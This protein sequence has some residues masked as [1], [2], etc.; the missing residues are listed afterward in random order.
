[1][2]S[3][4][5]LCIQLC[6]KRGIIPPSEILEAMKISS[7][8]GE[9]CLSSLSIVVPICEIISRILTSSTTIKCVDLSD[10]MLI[11]TGMSKILEALNNGSNITSLNLKGNN[12]SG[13]IASQLGDIFHH[14]NTLKHLYIKWNALGTDKA[15]FDK[16]CEGLC[17]NH[18]IEEIDLRY[19]QIT[20]Y[21]AE[22]LSNVLRKNRSLKIMNLA[23]NT[24]GLQGGQLILNGM[25]E[26][27]RIIQLNLRGNCIPT[28]II[29]A[30]DN[31]IHD[32][33]NKRIISQANITKT[34]GA[35]KITVLHDNSHEMC[36]TNSDGA[37][38]EEYRVI[39]RRMRRKLRSDRR[40]KDLF[41]VRERYDECKK[42][43]DDNSSSMSVEI[44]K[45][46]LNENDLCTNNEAVSSTNGPV[47]KNNSKETELIRKISEVN[48]I[49]QDRT[50]AI[51]ALT[52]EISMKDSEIEAAKMLSDQLRIKISQLEDENEKRVTEH[53]KEINDLKL[54][55]KSSEENW[56]K[57]YKELEEVNKTVVEK[58]KEWETKARYYEREIHKSSLEIISLRDKW[59]NKSQSYDNLI[60][61]SKTEI[62]RGKKELQE[63]ESRHK[64]ELNVLKNTLKET[65][66]ALEE[67]QI[68]LQKSRIELRDTLV[69]LSNVKSKL[70]Q[71][72]HTNAKYIRIDECLQK[73]K[74]EKLIIEEKFVDSQRT[75]ASL[76]RQITALENELI[77]PQRRYNLLK[78]DLDNEKE[79]ST[80]L[81]RELTE[82]RAHIKEQDIQMQM[83]NS[84]I[85]KLNTQINDIQRTYADDIR[86]R[87]REKKQLK[88][89]IVNKERDLNDLKAE[90]AQRASQLY[91][92]FGKYISSIRP[93]T[94]S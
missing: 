8:L 64:I 70:T 35:G 44:M 30:I 37:V 32:N 41:I 80:R 55:Q 84:Q 65:T 62:H 85:T 53:M 51:N 61:K 5:E 56:I 71:M 21:S 31:C 15:S 23:W 17:V 77:E 20:S 9:L 67:C 87:D 50:V 90:E 1:M 34:V 7:S 47:D 38:E 27:K 46:H 2:L 78:D 16:F 74:E 76:K 19:N 28:E 58:N 68:Q 79:K 4:Y 6:T 75:I 57:M 14:N 91:A 33:Q 93:N 40:P 45:E 73:I 52:N 66:E 36:S 29:E 3:D 88:E 25:K 26:N 54:L 43:S 24:L 89:I 49:L 86:E 59:I 82:E 22:A 13:A 72:E 48:K 92:A 83:M 18:N 39:K 10:C 42:K 94:N 69:Q 11:S 63:K 12:I 60:V 81:K